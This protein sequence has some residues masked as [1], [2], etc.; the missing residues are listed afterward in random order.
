MTFPDFDG[1]NYVGDDTYSDHP[2]MPT[3]FWVIYYQGINS[4]W[5]ITTPF[6]YE[7]N[8]YKHANALYE[9]PMKFLHYT[10]QSETDRPAQVRAVKKVKKI[11]KPAKK[12]RKVRTVV[13]D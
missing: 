3:E 9:R 8:M 11:A 2:E 5:Y 1:R 7:E 10:L 13:T 6:L 12:V 4:K